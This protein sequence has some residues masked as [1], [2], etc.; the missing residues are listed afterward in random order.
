MA[1]KEEYT[2]PNSYYESLCGEVFEGEYEGEYDRGD[3]KAIPWPIIRIKHKSEAMKEGLD[4][5]VKNFEGKIWKGYRN[6]CLYVKSDDDVQKG[7]TFKIVNYKRF[8]L[9]NWKEPDKYSEKCGYYFIV[10]VE[11]KLKKEQ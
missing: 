7:T 6:G 9:E 1:K 11:K 2:K 4:K 3:Y 5:I 8:A 10:Q